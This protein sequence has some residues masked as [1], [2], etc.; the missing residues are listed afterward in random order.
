MTIQA[1]R[2]LGR[3]VEHCGDFFVYLISQKLDKATRKAWE[4]HLGNTTEYLTYANLDAFLAASIR[5]LEN[6]LPIICANKK[7]TNNNKTVV[8]SHVTN[9]LKCVVCKQNHA[10]STCPDFKSKTVA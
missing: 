3:P 6:I 4:L 1:L 10:W 5:A 8:Q 7:K 9:A 2:Y